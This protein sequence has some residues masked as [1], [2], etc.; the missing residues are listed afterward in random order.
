MF[1]ELNIMFPSSCMAWAAIP[2]CFR[3]FKISR[4]QFANKLN[5]NAYKKKFINMNKS[6]MK[7]S[8]N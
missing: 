8:V 2:I 4:F 1:S 6:S 7:I 3:Y 5:D